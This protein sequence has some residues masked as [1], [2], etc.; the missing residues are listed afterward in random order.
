[1]AGVRE[2]GEAELDGGR[3]VPYLV[4]DLISGPTLDERLNQGALPAGVALRVVAEVAEALAE[5]H[6]AG[7]AHG[8][9]VPGNIVFG[10]DQVKVTDAG[11]WPLRPRPTGGPVPG[12]L[13]YAAPELTYGR[14][15]PAADMYALGVVYVA[16]L[17]GIASGGP[18]S[19]AEGAAGEDWPAGWPGRPGRDR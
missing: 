19:P 3:T 2:F 15:N 6:R 11:L 16:C 13:G 1:M 10:P 7:V 14:P 5:A 9:L 12:G 17:A 8:H 4:R 18:R